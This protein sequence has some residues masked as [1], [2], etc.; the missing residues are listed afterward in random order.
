MAGNNKAD[1]YTDEAKLVQ[2]M[3]DEACTIGSDGQVTRNHNSTIS[4][5]DLIRLLQV[6]QG[7][8]K[9]RPYDVVEMRWVDPPPKS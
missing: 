1:N 7:M 5:A 2:S 8:V 6:Q 9:E 3:I 4:N